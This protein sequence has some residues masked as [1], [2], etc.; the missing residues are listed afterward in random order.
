MFL[1]I[2]T[3]FLTSAKHPMSDIHTWHGQIK[4]CPTHKR[5]RQFKTTVSAPKTKCIACWAVYLSDKLEIGLYADDLA[6]LVRF[7]NS[8]PKTMKTSGVKY[9]ETA[10]EEK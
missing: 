6:S 5:Q 9:V 1:V 7:S 8:F 10:K 3:S 2:V 4:E